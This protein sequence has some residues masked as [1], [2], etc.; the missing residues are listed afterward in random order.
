MLKFAPHQEAIVMKSSWPSVLAV[1]FLAA[2][3]ALAG[4]GSPTASPA[5]LAQLR[6]AI[7]Q[8]PAPATAAPE[9]PGLTGQLSPQWQP[10]TDCQSYG[11]G[12]GRFLCYCIEQC[13]PCGGVASS[14]CEPNNPNF[15][16]NCVQ[17]IDTCL[18]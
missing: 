8:P 3:A 9:R 5:E 4:T 18:P 2:S 15:Y 17:D 7:F 16:C 14:F 6:A 10:Q 13:Q 1:L 11:S 12:C